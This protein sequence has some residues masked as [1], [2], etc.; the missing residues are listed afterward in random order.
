MM[1]KWVDNRGYFGPDRRRRPAKRLLDR[2]KFDES[3]QAP[4][5]S[6]L[7]RRIRVRIAGPS[8]DDHRHAL[9][10]L[11]A[12]IAEAN[13]LG[14]RQCAAAL[15]EADHA[16]R[17]HGRKGGEIADACVVRALEHAGANR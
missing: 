9:D 10:M 13:G 6:A 14:W 1:S 7:L 11:K 16:L 3:G 2:R 4:P 12:A 15:N 17:T 5:V 8:D